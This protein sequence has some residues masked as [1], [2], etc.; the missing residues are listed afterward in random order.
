M[1][2]ILTILVLSVTSSALAQISLKKG[3]MV[4][5]CSFRLA[6]DNLFPLAFKLATN[7]YVL[8][9]IVLYLFSL[10]TWLYVL[11]HVDVS[12]AYP[13]MALG[14]VMVLVL[15]YFLF[16]EDINSYRMLGVAAIVV[17]I[18]LI[19]KSSA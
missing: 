14:V 2:K 5:D 16:N 7:A 18:V 10:I 1:I 9:G 19:G 12:F 3:M 11:K 13:F 17:G 6:L 15:S 4:C 8:G